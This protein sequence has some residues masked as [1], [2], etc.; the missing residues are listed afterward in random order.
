MKLDLLERVDV[1]T[2]LEDL[3]PSPSFINKKYMGGIFM[4]FVVLSKTVALS[5]LLAIALLYSIVNNTLL[6]L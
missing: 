2:C 1:S 5:F 4:E 3:F 6:N